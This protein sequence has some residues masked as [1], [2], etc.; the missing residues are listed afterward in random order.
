MN[1]FYTPDIRG[2]TGILDPAESHH[3]I[4]VLR[5][6]AGD[7]VYL[8][9]GTGGFYKG[10]IS[11]ADSRACVV[12]I[13]QSEYEFG[14]RKFRIHIAIAPTK[15]IE[16]FEWFL[17]K[18]TEIGIDEISPLICER[19]ERKIIREDRLQKVIAS[20]MKQ[21]L[22]AYMPKLNA[23]SLF[24]RFV[25]MPF[26]GEKF[27]AHC[28][29]G[30]RKDLIGIKQAG[31]QFTLLIGPEGDFSENEIKL[32]ISKGFIPVSFGASRL[33]TETAGV[34]ACQIIADLKAL[35]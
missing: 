5:L 15:N 33:R 25:E 31:D 17:E 28:M 35:Q 9:D 6:N 4:K 12:N 1:I 30:E 24:D 7:E 26:G 22:K 34:V 14:K 3:C 27:I 32:A 21:S 11:L 20:A 29:E 10:S 16:R 18:A 13:S 2:N 8:V 23:L 19:S